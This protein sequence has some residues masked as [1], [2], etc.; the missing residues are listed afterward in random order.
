MGLGG[1]GKKDLSSD[2]RTGVELGCVGDSAV[3]AEH[4]DTLVLVC[5]PT[6]A[7]P[8]GNSENR[9]RSSYKEDD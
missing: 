6:L 3:M 9:M 8:Q 2:S 5:S 4:Q 7:L 1:G